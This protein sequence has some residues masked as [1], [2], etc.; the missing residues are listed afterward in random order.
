MF[1]DIECQCC[2]KKFQRERK[3]VNRSVKL[4][5]PFYC[6]LSCCRSDTQKGKPCRNPE[7][8]KRH[9]G[10]R[11][12][13]Y[14]QFRYHLRKAKS[15]N[16]ECDLTLE[17]LKEV[18]ENQDGVCGYTG[19]KLTHHMWNTTKI[20]TTASLDRIDSSLGYVRGNVQFV[21]VMANFAKS[22]FTHEEMVLFCKSISER[23]K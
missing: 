17:Y 11:N 10:N 16:K 2:G 23:W 8:I 5:R 9:A 21:S 3:E 7:F 1:I 15:R 19:M 20:P 6:S 13:E 12:D 14:S 4:G 18:W 22:D